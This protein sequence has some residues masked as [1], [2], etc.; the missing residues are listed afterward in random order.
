MRSWIYIILL[1]VVAACNKPEKEEVVELN[2]KVTFTLQDVD[3]S[4]REWSTSSAYAQRSDSAIHLFATNEFDELLSIL[5]FDT[6]TGRLKL[7]FADKNVIKFKRVKAGVDTIYSNKKSDVAN[8]FLNITSQ[9]PDK[10]TISGDFQ[11]RAHHTEFNYVWLLNGKFEDVPYFSVP[12]TQGE[13]EIMFPNDTTGGSG[14][15]P[16]PLACP[17]S[18]S[19][20]VAFYIDE[21]PFVVSGN[22]QIK[23]AYR[24]N[25]RMMLQ[26]AYNNFDTLFIGVTPENTFDTQ[27]EYNVGKTL[28]NKAY[29][30]K[31]G[32]QF[33][34]TT[35]TATLNLTTDSTITG[36]FEMTLKETSQAVTTINISEGKIRN[37]NAKQLIFAPDTSNRFSVFADNFYFVCDT[38]ET[39]LIDSAII[40][41]NAHSSVSK[42]SFQIILP[43]ELIAIEYNLSNDIKVNHTNFYG[44]T[45]KAVSGTVEIIAHDKVNKTIRGTIN[46]QTFDFSE[47][48]TVELVLGQFNTSY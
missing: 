28:K 8:G 12:L 44:V 39:A 41:I 47:N 42:E 32:S 46:V 33:V 36:G 38:V 11:I 9:N 20:C 15:E 30:Q 37:V 26:V 48:R 21:T 34:A 3:R 45:N 6:D 31:S 40:E 2:T 1:L 19:P 5:L 10:S 17:D 24:E 35:G 23:L 18:T 43:K 13:L 14:Q 7:D 25:D 4:T 27:S 29:I 22:N 16:N